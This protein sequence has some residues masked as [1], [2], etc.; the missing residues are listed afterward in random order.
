M[1]PDSE[2]VPITLLRNAGLF[3]DRRRHA[4][5]AQAGSEVRVA[6]G[7][8]VDRSHWDQLGE[9]SRYLVRMM[10]FARTRATPPTFSHWSAAAWHGFPF[11][12]PIPEVMH[13][14]VGRTPGGRS[15]GG[16]IAHS[17][18]VPDED[19]EIVNGFRCTS[20]ERT[21]VDLAAS[22]PSA[23]VVAI[24]DHLLSLRP[25]ARARLRDAWRRALPLRGYRRAES[26]IA[27]ADGE[28]GSPLE[29]V[30]RAT[31]REIGAPPPV[32]QR[33]FHDRDG[34]IGRV[35]FCWPAHA[36]VGEADGDVKYLD[37]A[38]RGGRT[39][40]RV[41]VDEK[42]REDRLR[43]LGLRVVRWRWRTARNPDALGRLLADA[44]LPLRSTYR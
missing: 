8:Y 13:V 40:A 6:R 12:G 31:M 32:L 42:V 4:R 34:L 44:G 9:R 37:E 1:H 29:S 21:V 5:A 36:V 17:I 20:P 39:A 14:A 38:L 30:S 15:K 23:D 11:I 41:V 26:L 25:D 35:D 16:A 24:A 18:E 3:E 28:A 19:L 33:A 10:A 22:A 2:T 27:F 7:A 43:S